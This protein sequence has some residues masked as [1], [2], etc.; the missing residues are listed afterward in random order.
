MSFYT[1][2]NPVNVTLLLDQTYNARHFSPSQYFSLPCL[3]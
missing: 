3:S 2:S 1:I